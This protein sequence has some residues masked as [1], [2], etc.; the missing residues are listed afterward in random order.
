MRRDGRLADDRLLAKAVRGI[1]AEARWEALDLTTR[2]G[3][4]LAC[5]LLRG[6]SAECAGSP[7][8]R[9]QLLGLAL[10]QA[11]AALRQQGAAPADIDLS[12][13]LAPRRIHAA[14]EA[15][16]RVRSEHLRVS[17]SDALRR[18]AESAANSYRAAA[19][20]RRGARVTAEL[21][22]EDAVLNRTLWA[23]ARILADEP[24]RAFMLACVPYLERMAGDEGRPSFLTRLASRARRGP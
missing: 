10:D 16:I 7:S 20:R 8:G 18:H 13:F 17:G 24:Q 22:R 3:R 9:D 5:D 15:R 19:P 2:R 14:V 12:S 1:C 23:D 11:A 6:H 21:L 4:S